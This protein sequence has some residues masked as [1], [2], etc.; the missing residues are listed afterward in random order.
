MF[1]WGRRVVMLRGR[2]D[3][4]VDVVF[5]TGTTWKESRKEVEFVILYTL[6]GGTGCERRT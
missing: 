2:H 4:K 6:R 5:S 1:G 3:C